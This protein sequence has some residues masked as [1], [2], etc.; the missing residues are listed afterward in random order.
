[1]FVRFNVFPV[2]KNGKTLIIS[3]PPF[4]LTLDRLAY[5][6]GPILVLPQCRFDALESA[7]R[8]TGLHVLLPLPWSPRLFRHPIPPIWVR[9]LLDLRC[10]L[11]GG[12]SNER[13]R[14]SVVTVAWLATSNATQR[15]LLHSSASP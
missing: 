1:V 8:K 5:E 10:C 12:S 4:Q 11:N 2:L 9:T 13:L 3:L 6:V 7:G 15:P 14:G